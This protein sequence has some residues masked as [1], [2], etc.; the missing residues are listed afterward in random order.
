VSAYAEM[1]ANCNETAIAAMPESAGNLSQKHSSVRA[2][3]PLVGY[4]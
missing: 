1:R 4:A 2:N 3:I